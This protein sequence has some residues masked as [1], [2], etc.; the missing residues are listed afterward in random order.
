MSFLYH[1]THINNLAGI[2]TQGLAPPNKRAASSVAGATTADQLANQLSKQ[3]T[4]NKFNFL[5]LF[6]KGADLDQIRTYPA[7][8]LPLPSMVITGEIR[9]ESN[10][11]YSVDKVT[12][13][14]KVEQGCKDYLDALKSRSGA[15]TSVPSTVSGA[16]ASSSSS[17]TSLPVRN[18]S[19]FKT[20]WEGLIADFSTT[21]PGHFL[22]K[23]ASFQREYYYRAENAITS[24]HIYLFQYSA[25]K[26]YYSGYVDTIS[27]GDHHRIAILRLDNSVLNDSQ[28]DPSQPEG[29]IS[30]TVVAAEHLSYVIGLTKLQVT[31]SSADA[32]AQFD[33][34]Q[35]LPLAQ[36]APASASAIPATDASSSSSTA[37]QPASLGEEG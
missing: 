12:L 33:A 34:L 23:L 8:E 28:S 1:S 19:M 21:H 16:A 15:L 13:G 30:K 5:Y 17:S 31:N 14:N 29:L 27:G 3:K 36:Y 32:I 9:A 4:F 20:Q 2:K 10:F 24:E 11:N 25:L 22:S 18:S 7:S 6:N 26:K 35:W 37:P